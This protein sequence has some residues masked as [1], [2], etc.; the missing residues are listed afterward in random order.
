M[1]NCRLGVCVAQESQK[2]GDLIPLCVGFDVGED[3]RLEKFKIIFDNDEVERPIVVIPRLI[4]P[5]GNNYV[6]Y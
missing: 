4:L 5:F 3:G 1:L 2:A 6:K